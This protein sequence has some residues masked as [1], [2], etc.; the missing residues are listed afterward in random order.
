MHALYTPQVYTTRVNEER[1]QANKDWYAMEDAL[2][3]DSMEEDFLGGGNAPC[4]VIEEES[5]MGSETSSDPSG[6]SSPAPYR[7]RTP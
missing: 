1:G 3:A 2:L 4:D 7:I 6:F 5:F